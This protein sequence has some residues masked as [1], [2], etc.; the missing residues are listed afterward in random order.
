SRETLLCDR[1][2]ANLNG[3]LKVHLRAV[4]AGNRGTVIAAGRA[5]ATHGVQLLR[6]RGG[7][8]ASRRSL[9]LRDLGGGCPGSR[10]LRRTGADLLLRENTR[11][12]RRR[13]RLVVLLRSRTRCSGARPSNHG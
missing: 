12:R 6:R 3:P 8:K 10:G 9:Q 7:R 1:R 13:R 5:P 4:A 11:P 2:T